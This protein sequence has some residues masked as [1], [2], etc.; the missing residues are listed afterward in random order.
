MPYNKDNGVDL[1]ADEKIATRKK[2]IQYLSKEY[3]PMACSWCS[4][5]GKDEHAKKIPVAVQTQ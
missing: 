1:H 5:N 4:G 2:L 3:A